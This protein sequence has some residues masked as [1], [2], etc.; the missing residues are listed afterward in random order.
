MLNYEI[1]T[2]EGKPIMKLISIMISALTLLLVI[3]PKASAQ[4]T[5]PDC[6]RRCGVRTEMF[7]RTGPY[8][9]LADCM[10]RCS[11][12]FWKKADKKDKDLEE[13]R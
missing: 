3:Y 4:E 8:N 1:R 10:D 2:T 9:V 12:D 13:T 6:E 7:G 11:R 5:I